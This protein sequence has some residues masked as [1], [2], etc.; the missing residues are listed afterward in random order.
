[1]SRIAS[2]APVPLSPFPQGKGRRLGELHRVGLFCP[3]L[4]Y[5]LLQSCSF[6]LAHAVQYQPGW[7]FLA[8]RNLV[9][10]AYLWFSSG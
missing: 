5:E 2:H 8:V 4:L 10:A 1:M 6:S 3:D 7:Q 9:L